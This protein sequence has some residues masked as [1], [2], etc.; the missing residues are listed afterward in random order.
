MTTMLQL[1]QQAANELGI[2]APTSVAGNTNQ[3]T[4]Q[5][6]AL[7][8][9]SGYELMDK[10]AWRAL[11][12]QHQFYTEYLTTTGSWVASAQTITSIP[13][14]SG[15]DTTYIAVGPNVGLPQNCFITSVDSAT[16]VTVD[17]VIGQTETAETVYFQKMKYSLPS[18]YQGPVNRTQW[19]K[20]KHWEMLGP[21]DAQ[22]WEWL[23][24]GYISTGPRVRW[25]LLGQYF[26]IWPGFS[27]AEFLGFEYTSNA[28]AST[29]AGVAKTSFTLDTDTCIYPDRLMVLNLKLKYFEAKGFDTTA[30]YRDFTTQLEA[31]IAKDM[32][33]ANLS[34]APK[35]GTVL[36]GWENI[37]D[38]VPV[39]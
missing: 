14:T 2:A 18:D 15:L 30:M 26:Q 16:Q 4:V 6:L 32:G 27:N 23:L 38:Q 20:S 8:N 22:Q 1:V 24:S 39:P 36:L 13:S 29:A 11:T 34:F 35:P 7:L 17:Q 3:D 9:A 37:P 21:T 19:D 12:K 25:R 28:W 5:M 33:A 31:G 10:H